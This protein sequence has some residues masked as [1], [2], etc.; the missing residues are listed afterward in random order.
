M[1]GDYSQVPKDILATIP[2]EEVEA[3]GSA[4]YGAAIA[5]TLITILVTLSIMILMIIAYWKLFAKAGQK[6]WK[7][8]IPIY[9]N[10]ILFRIAGLSPWL[11]LVYFASVI[12]VIGGLA[13]LGITIYLMYKLAVAFGKDGAFTVGLV[14]LSPI[15]LMILAF[16]KSEYQLSK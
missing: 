12:P 16:G 10:V 2:T 7:S 8:L 15:F 9:N 14:L 3:I 11:I 4:V 5:T 6:G 1:Y 13:V